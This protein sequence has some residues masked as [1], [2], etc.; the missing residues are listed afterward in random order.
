MEARHGI[1]SDDGSWSRQTK[2][3]VQANLVLRQDAMWAAHMVFLSN[4]D[5]LHQNHL[6]RSIPL[7]SVRAQHS[8]RKEAAVEGRFPELHVYSVYSHGTRHN[9]RPSAT[10]NST[11]TPLLLL[12]CAA[13]LTS[14]MGVYLR[15]CSE[16]RVCLKVSSRSPKSVVGLWDLVGH[17]QCEFRLIGPSSALENAR[18]VDC[19]TCRRVY[20][21]QTR[22]K[23]TSGGYRGGRHPATVPCIS[24]QRHRTSC[25]LCSPQCIW[26]SCLQLHGPW[27]VSSWC[28][29][30]CWCWCCW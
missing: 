19:H 4:I 5:S 29:C 18:I 15:T 26:P 30:W 23:T 6:M 17:I 27:W 25:C 12:C 24:R 2:V 14:R 20:S 16:L 8:I 28:W 1:K 11:C 13:F 9:S 22:R 3:P 10:A 7:R 21:C